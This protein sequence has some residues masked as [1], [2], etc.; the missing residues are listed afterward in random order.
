LPVRDER[1]LRIA[2]DDV[3]DPVVVE[4]RNGHAPGARLTRHIVD[5]YLVEAGLEEN[6]PGI[7]SGSN[8]ATRT[9]EP[10]RV[11]PRARPAK[12]R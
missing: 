5:E 6:C 2:G 12:P 1:L 8:S 11:H 3:V 9:M 7:R 10:E 4:V